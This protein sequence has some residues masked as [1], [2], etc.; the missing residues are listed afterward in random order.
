[1]IDWVTILT[2]HNF[3]NTHWENRFEGWIVPC[4]QGRKIYLSIACFINLNKNIENNSCLSYST[5]WTNIHKNRN[6]YQ[7]ISFNTWKHLTLAKNLMTNILLI[8][9]S[10]WSM[11]IKMEIDIILKPI[12]IRL[13]KVWKT[14]VLGCLLKIF[15]LTIILIFY[16]CY[17]NNA[18]MG[19]C[20][21][22]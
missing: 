11:H 12:E 8:R 10:I 14:S 16:L 21:H 5:Q 18:I 3:Q 7:A 2:M 4:L 20:S 22:L 6:P 19:K 15:L 13:I 17:K 9:L 1:M